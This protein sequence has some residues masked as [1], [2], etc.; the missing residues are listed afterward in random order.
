MSY[1]AEQHRL[2]FAY[3]G[4][5][6]FEK[7]DPNLLRTSTFSESFPGNIELGPND[8][9]KSFTGD[10]TRLNIWSKAMKTDQIKIKSF[11]DG[12]EDNIAVAGDPDL[13]E[14]ELNM[15]ELK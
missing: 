3:T 12:W 15:M 8:K 10:I 11:C 7:I 9:A 5:I 13:L 1:D 4:N 14:W 6:I 2:I